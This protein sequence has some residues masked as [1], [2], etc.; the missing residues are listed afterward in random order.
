MALQVG[1]IYIHRR[2]LLTFR[3]VVE[4]VWMPEGRRRKDLACFPWG[5]RS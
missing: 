2:L 5:C 4:V 3:K 1:P